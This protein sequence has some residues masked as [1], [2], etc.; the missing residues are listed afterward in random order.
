MTVSAPNL[1]YQASGG[2]WL[3]V[4]SGAVVIHPGDNPATLFPGA[5]KVL[6]LTAGAGNTLTI[7]QGTR[8]RS[9]RGTLEVSAAPLLELIN[10]VNVED[11]VRGVVPA[12]MP[13]TFPLEALKAQAVAA[14]SFGLANIGKHIADGADVCDGEHCQTYTGASAESAATNEA[15]D[16]TAGEILLVGGKVLCAQYSADCGGFTEESRQLGPASVQPDAVAGSPALCSSDP[17]HTWTLD[18]TQ[19]IILGAAGETR[20]TP[21]RRLKVVSRDVSGRL[22]QLALTDD[23]GDRPITG[24]ALRKA[25]GVNSMKSLLCHFSADPV[26]GDILISG[27]GWGHGIGM[28]Q[29]GAH[30]LALAPYKQ[31][32]KQILA[33]YYPGSVL[34]TDGGLTVHAAGALTASM[35]LPP[36]P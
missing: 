6:S 7:S 31:S 9:Y 27:S 22:Q 11:Y 10:V 20:S 21:L 23:Y 15:V 33:H 18:V 26:T 5:S 24:A 32:Y 1:T 13:R 8:T 3:A 25:L 2:H 17:A 30:A 16:G 29:W 4:P 14:R 19:Q 35:T 36:V 12:E 28:C 34:G